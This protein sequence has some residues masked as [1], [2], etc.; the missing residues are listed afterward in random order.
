MFKTSVILQSINIPQQRYHTFLSTLPLFSRTV[1]QLLLQQA[2]SLRLRAA[3]FFR[4]CK[5]SNQ[6]RTQHTLPVYQ[7]TC[8]CVY[9]SLLELR[10]HSQCSQQRL[11]SAPA[12]E[13]HPLQLKDTH[14]W[15]NCPSLLHQEIF[16][17]YWITLTAYKYAVI[18]FMVKNKT[19]SRL[20]ISFY[21]TLPLESSKCFSTLAFTSSIPLL[22]VSWIHSEQPF[23]PS[24]LG[25]R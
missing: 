24:T 8:I 12:F 5:R 10:M 14:W 13:S 4:C 21:F 19:L 23:T 20:H 16:P 22:S 9:P 11:T 3:L 18:F 15:R 17:L 25:R 1:S 2:S 7:P 6:K